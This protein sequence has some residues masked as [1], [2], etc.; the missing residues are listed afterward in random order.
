M[1]I[2]ITPKISG[3][4]IVKNL[5]YLLFGVF[6]TYFPLKKRFTRHGKPVEEDIVLDIRPPMPVLNITIN[7]IPD[8]LIAGQVF[9]TSIAVTNTG[10]RDLCSLK[11]ILSHPQMF[12]FGDD[13]NSGS[14]GQNSP[15][16]IY[17]K[18]SLEISSLLTLD[19]S[20]TGGILKVGETVHIP[21][22]IRGEEIGLKN[23]KFI[24]GYCAAVIIS[25]RFRMMINLALELFAFSSFF[26]S[27]NH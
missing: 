23:C 21:L 16:F 22:R 27:S 19:L 18:N 17:S 26:K 6:P 8:S 9:K 12:Y 13:A 11:V 24:F 2:I 1:Q 20:G 5:R 14:E 10:G 15:H 25:L 4:I 3:E 7:P